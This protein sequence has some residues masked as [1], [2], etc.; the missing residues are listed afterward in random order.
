[1]QLIFPYQSKAKLLNSIGIKIS[2]ARHIYLGN[3]RFRYKRLQ[4]LNLVLYS[5]GEFF[6][7]AFQVQPCH[8]IFSINYYYIVGSD[9]TLEQTQN[10]LYRIHHL[11]YRLNCFILSSQFL[12]TTAIRSH[13]QF[14]NWRNYFT[15]HISAILYY[16]SKVS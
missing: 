13:S 2:R 11:R 7:K 1:M 14:N 6:T 9:N 15:C 4:R 5:I 12:S 3:N 16:K 8:I 10:P